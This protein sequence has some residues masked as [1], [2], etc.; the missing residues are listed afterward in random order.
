M[1]RAT[2]LSMG[3]F[4]VVLASLVRTRPLPMFVLRMPFYVTSAGVLFALPR[5]LLLLIALVHEF[6][7][8]FG[9]QDDLY[10]CEFA[11][12]MLEV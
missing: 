8:A 3:S 4:V 11:L 2:M 5:L 1:A 6:L 10:E 7:Q 9:A 12:S